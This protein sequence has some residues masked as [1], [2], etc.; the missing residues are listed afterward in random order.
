MR[1]QTQVPTPVSS[2]FDLGFQDARSA[3]YRA[4]YLAI[5]LTILGYLLWRSLYIGGVDWLQVLLW[6]IFPDVV[7]F[8][9]IGFPS[10]GREWPSWGP[11]VYN[12][13][14]TILVWGAAF[15]ASWAILGVFYWPLLGWLGH[16]TV[17]RTVG[18]ALRA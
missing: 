11:S 6:V 4:E 14:H 16:I 3:L 17:D 5:S 1:I 8:L 18:Y 12:S 9:A 10:K 15:A 13:F 7:S 2:S